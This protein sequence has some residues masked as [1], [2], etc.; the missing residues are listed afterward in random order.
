MLNNVKKGVL[1]QSIV[2]TSALKRKR[3]DN[4]LLHCPKQ[5][6]FGC[7]CPHCLGSSGSSLPQSRR[8]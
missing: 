3:V 4:L 8:P 7:H 2:A 6:H 1:P 5:D